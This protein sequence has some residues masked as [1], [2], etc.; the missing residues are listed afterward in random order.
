MIEHEVAYEYLLLSLIE[1]NLE[2]CDSRFHWPAFQG[3]KKNASAWYHK[4]Y[5]QRFGPAKGLT[6]KRPSLLLV[7]HC[8]AKIID[9]YCK[10]N[11]VPYF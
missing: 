4:N 6:S 1:F 5:R 2:L 7:S 3:L 8:V 11:V 10:N 9:L